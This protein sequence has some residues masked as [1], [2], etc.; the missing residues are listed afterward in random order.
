M[1]FHFNKTWMN[2]FLCSRNCG[3]GV[4]ENCSPNQRSVPERDW[5]T[6]VRVCKLCDQTMNGSKSKP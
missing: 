6:P 5:L 1:N 4:C 2:I 3:D